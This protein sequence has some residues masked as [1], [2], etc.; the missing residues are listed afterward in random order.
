MR[1]NWPRRIAAGQ[2]QPSQPSLLA[3]G[4]RVLACHACGV[5]HNLA[6]PGWM[7]SLMAAAMARHRIKP[8]TRLLLKSH[9]QPPF[10]GTL[11]LSKRCQT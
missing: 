11:K 9:M 7:T 8:S 5:K 2:S 1:A 3:P 6:A 4:F 10:I